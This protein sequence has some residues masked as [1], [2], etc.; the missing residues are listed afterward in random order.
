MSKFSNYLLGKQEDPLA[1]M[2]KYAQLG[3][4]TAPRE[5]ERPAGDEVGDEITKI[6]KNKMVEG[7]KKQ[8]NPMMYLQKDMGDI[9]KIASYV[10]WQHPYVIKSFA[11]RM[12]EY[13]AI[14]DAI[15][16]QLQAI[17]NIIETDNIDDKEKSLLAGQIVYGENEEITNAIKSAL[18][19][20]SASKEHQRDLER[21]DANTES[22]GKQAEY[23][24]KKSAADAA[25]AQSYEN[26]RHSNTMGEK[27]YGDEL[28]R[29][30]ID[31]MNKGN[32]QL[33][34]LKD[35]RLNN[36]IN[37][38]RGQNG[39]SSIEEAAE[40]AREFRRKQLRKMGGQ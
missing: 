32:E 4:A 26:L 20:N 30:R 39:P 24:T 5:E 7:I 17:G 23:W 3:A 10:G 16:I 21:I 31:L 36:Y 14:D 34:G 1:L 18:K 25:A 6:Y 13:L 15:P 33:S 29:G 22:V 2:S 11:D 8:A 40:N 35:N 19:I 38:M 28:S 27:A 37:F 12:K 9:T